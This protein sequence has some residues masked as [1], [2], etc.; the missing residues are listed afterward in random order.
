MWLQKQEWWKQKYF[1]SFINKLQNVKC[2]CSTIAHED[3]KCIVLSFFLHDSDSSRINLNNVSVVIVY[4]L[5]GQ[6]KIDERN[7]LC[8]LAACKFGQLAF[9]KCE[10]QYISSIS[11]WFH[12]GNIKCWLFS[13]NDAEWLLMIVISIHVEWWILNE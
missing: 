5:P 6:R 4:Q 7:S 9:C 3:L 12:V 2:A 11:Q 1:L 13:I 10:D 8:G